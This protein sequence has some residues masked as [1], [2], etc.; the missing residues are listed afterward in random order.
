MENQRERLIRL[1]S[2]AKKKSIK[3]NKKGETSSNY[4]NRK[5]SCLYIHIPKTGGRYM[6]KILRIEKINHSNPGHRTALYARGKIEDFENKFSFAC[7][8]NPYERFLS[9]CVFNGLRDFEKVSNQVIEGDVSAKHPVHFKTQKSFVTNK[10]GD[11]IIKYIGRFEKFNEFIEG[12]KE[13]GVDVTNSHEFEEN[14]SSDW[15]TRLTEKTKENI[16]KIYKEDFEL[17]NYDM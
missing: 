15:E 17:F 6:R 11:I 5:N 8:R 1:K 4:L 12:L 10:N 16:R 14:K 2:L 3:N 7:V 13:R 9:A